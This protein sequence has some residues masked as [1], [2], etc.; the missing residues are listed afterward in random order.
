MLSLGS[1]EKFVATPVVSNALDIV[2]STSTLVHKVEADESDCVLIF[3]RGVRLLDGSRMFISIWHEQSRGTLCVRAYSLNSIRHHEL[4]LD[5][6]DWDRTGRGELVTMTVEQKLQ[7]CEQLAASL[8][9][10]EDGVVLQLFSCNLDASSS[11]IAAAA[12]TEYT[13]EDLR[14]LKMNESLIIVLTKCLKMNGSLIIVWVEHDLQESALSINA[15]KFDTSTIYSASVTESEW[16][17][18]VGNRQRSMPTMSDSEK[19]E[20][21]DVIS[22]E[23]TLT[24]P[25]QDGKFWFICGYLYVQL[26]TAATSPKE[27]STSHSQSSN[28]TISTLKR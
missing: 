16:C 18:C 2:S 7:L 12:G 27:I 6:S 22:R 8:G 13:S 25:D 9:V 4:W 14:G 19:K 10:N 1:T 15:L 5:S 3:S 20:L 28:S 24:D 11:S 26:K 17:H 23:S 21:A